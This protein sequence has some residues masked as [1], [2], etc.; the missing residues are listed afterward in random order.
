M[1]QNLRSALV[2]CLL[3]LA[4]AVPALGDTCVADPSWVNDPVLL[5]TIPGGGE[6]FCSFHQFA[7]QNF[8]TLI[9]K[10]AFLTF[11]PSDRV[12]V[13]TGTPA[14]WTNSPSPLSLGQLIKEAGSKKPLVAQNGQMVQFD[15][16]INRSWYDAVVA[17]RLYTT[18]QAF[19]RLCTN[20]DAPIENQDPNDKFGAIELKS[21][22]LPMNCT[23]QSGYVCSTDGK[24]GLTGMHIVQKMSNHQEW[25]WASFEHVAN[26]PDCV[27][28]GSKP[29]APFGKWSFFQRRFHSLRRTRPA[30]LQRQEL[31]PDLQRLPDHWGVERLSPDADRHR[32]SRRIGRPAG[33]PVERQRP[34]DAD[35]PQPH[36]AQEL[37]P[38]R[39]P[40]VPEGPD[41][42]TRARRHQPTG[43]PALHRLGRPR[44]H[45]HGDLHP[46]TQLLQLPRHLAVPVQ[47][48][49]AQD[50]LRRPGLL[51]GRTQSPVLDPAR[52]ERHPP[53][54]NVPPALRA[55][56]AKA[57]KSSGQK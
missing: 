32:R 42:Q 54:Q 12:F 24:Y 10:N 5:A 15:V 38:G 23:P 30:D 39:H 55:A 52:L 16:R 40:L 8:L 4:M 43:R 34:F 26:S 20:I 29:P 49:P 53:C 6:T 44:Q 2:L 22:W 46:A 21:S 35:Q 17:D 19:N 9:Q 27:A 3:T 45:H 28:L 47:L 18:A 13:A 25:V 11:V 41:R 1:R 37:R 56:A 57:A 51:R 48:Q 33:R 31:Q 14:P 36:G 50:T 7:W